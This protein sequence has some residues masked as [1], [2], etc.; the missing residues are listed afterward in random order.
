MPGAASSWRGLRIHRPA[1]YA[2]GVGDTVAVSLAW[3][4]FKSFVEAQRALRREVIFNGQRL[5]LTPPCIYLLT[6][7]T[8]HV[9]LRV[10]QSQDLWEEYKGSKY[11]IE[12]A[13]Q[14]SGNRIFIAEA[15][16]DNEE[17]KDV[18]R[19]LISQYQ[20]HFNEQRAA[21]YR[22][23]E[24]SHEGQVPL[25]LTGASARTASSGEFT[26]A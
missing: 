21:P 5:K 19:F 14:S 16:A 7:A 25:I 1:L 18:E 15:P 20:P 22:R 3:R 9:I 11:M 8:E 6:D 2:L 10:G 13:L 17:R 24:V 4:R 26:D 12:A 23:V